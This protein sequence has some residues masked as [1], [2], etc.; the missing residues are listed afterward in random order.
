MA[1]S[2]LRLVSPK[3]NE[4]KMKYK[5]FIYRVK[6]FWTCEFGFDRMFY[7]T[8]GSDLLSGSSG[9]LP[10][11]WSISGW[12]SRWSRRFYFFNFNVLLYDPRQNRKEQE[13]RKKKRVVPNNIRIKKNKM[14]LQDAAKCT[15]LTDLFR[16]GKVAVAGARLVMQLLYTEI[17]HICIY[18]YLNYKQQFPLLL[19][20]KQHPSISEEFL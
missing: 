4:F 11:G 2:T 17:I 19:S 1:V 14:L 5:K 9:R 7:I 16:G 6:D 18:V 13:N 8:S 12:T 3:C 20:H 15:K 10:N